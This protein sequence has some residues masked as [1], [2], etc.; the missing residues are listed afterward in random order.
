MI[1]LGSSLFKTFLECFY[2]KCYFGLFYW[3]DVERKWSNRTSVLCVRVWESFAFEARDQRNFWAVCSAR[4]CHFGRSELQFTTYKSAFNVFSLHFIY[5]YFVDVI[6]WEKNIRMLFIGDSLCLRIESSRISL[7][8]R[9]PL[10]AYDRCAFV[11]SS[12]TARGVAALFVPLI[13]LIRMRTR[14]EKIYISPR[15]GVKL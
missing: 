8:F 13:T 11:L 2:Y 14:E 5:M 4:P 9:I 15:R 3:Q 12:G 10:S 7:W 6:S 1:C